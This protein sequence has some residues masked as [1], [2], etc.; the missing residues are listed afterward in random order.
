MGIKTFLFT[1]KKISASIIFLL[2]CI[3]LLAYPSFKSGFNTSKAPW[4]LDAQYSEQLTIDADINSS[5]IVKTVDVIKI[6][7]TTQSHDDM[8]DLND[9]LK[10]KLVFE[11]SDKNFIEQF[12]LSSQQIIM[13]VDC[14][15]NMRNEYFHVVLIDNNNK[16]AGYFLFVECEDGQYAIIR[17]LQRE[18]GSSIYYNSSLLQL[19]K[20]ELRLID[21]NQSGTDHDNHQ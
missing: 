10:K 1:R 9:L 19:F 13:H 12:I 8:L 20:N 17:S 2:F 7:K 5:S 4:S 15:R 16:H 6:Y 21:R 14:K 11:S 18:G 3:I